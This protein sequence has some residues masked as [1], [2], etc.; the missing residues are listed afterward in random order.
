MTSWAIKGQYMEACSCDFL[1]PCIPR[2]ATTPAT[3]PFC[4]VAITFAIESG[5]YGAVTLDDVR[6]VFFAQSKAIMTQGDWIGG[7]IV[8]ASAS[9]AQVEAVTAIASGAAGGPFGMFAPMIADFRGVERHP[10]AFV[11][12]GRNVSV[13]IDGRLD[14][15]VVGV[16]SVTAPGECVAIDNTFHPANKRLNLATAARNVIS[17]FGIDWKGEPERT[18]GHFAP[19]DWRG[20]AA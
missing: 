3:H 19:F 7:L 12:D 14:Q 11:K 16:E 9:D 18:N 8:D 4:K 2:N 6:F 17:A 5:H 10:I 1:C 13:K 15:S 20:E